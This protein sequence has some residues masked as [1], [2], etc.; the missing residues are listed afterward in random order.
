VGRG[1]DRPDEVVDKVIAA[2]KPWFET[3]KSRHT[4]YMQEYGIS[5]TDYGQTVNSP[6]AEEIQYGH[7]N[8]V[9][10]TVV[11]NV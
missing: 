7:A 11:T 2:F 10:D 9:I 6:Q 8:N 4:S 1:N 5:R 3:R